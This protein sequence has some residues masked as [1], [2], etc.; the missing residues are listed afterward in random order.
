MVWEMFVSRIAKRSC[1]VISIF[2]WLPHYDLELEEDENKIILTITGEKPW[3]YSFIALFLWIIIFKIDNTKLSYIRTHI[4]FSVVRTN[5][6]CTESFVPTSYVRTYTIH[7]HPYFLYEFFS[8]V[9]LSFSKILY[10]IQRTLVFHPP[11]PHL[12]R[13][14]W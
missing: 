9:K 14:C 1:I 3:K 12:H 11:W 5:S 4:Q 13:H 8:P 10:E 6:V 7:V 2:I